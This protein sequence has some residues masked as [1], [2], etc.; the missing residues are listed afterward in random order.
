MQNGCRVSCP[1]DFGTRHTGVGMSSGIIEITNKSFQAHFS[2]ADY[3]LNQS[4]SFYSVLEKSTAENRYNADQAALRKARTHAR[5]CIISVVA[6]TES[7]CH[8][9]V[10][11]MPMRT[12]DKIPQEWL[13]QQYQ[14][15]K[16]KFGHWL[17][18]QKIR[19]VPV[20]CCH[21]LRPPS[22][23][24]KGMEIELNKLNEIKEIRNKL[25]HGGKVETKYEMEIRQNGPHEIRDENIPDN[26]WPMTGFPRDVR[27][28]SY[29]DAKVAYVHVLKIVR[30]M[31]SYIDEGIS[32]S[33]LCENVLTYEGQS[34]TISREHVNGKPPMWCSIILGND[35]APRRP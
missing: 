2:D 31:I 30:K 24:Y 35:T 9:I 21:D 17:F 16:R 25:A 12:V 33:F 13:P 4:L 22:H 20:L 27:T 1:S 15:H 11:M 34:Y 5:A 10:D 26:F 23:Y 14:K 3:H 29:G 28:L 32:L 19:F 8:C 7:L 18:M 6:G